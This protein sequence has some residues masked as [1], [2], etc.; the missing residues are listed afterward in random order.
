MPITP[1]LHDHTLIQAEYWQLLNG[2]CE[3]LGIH[4]NWLFD[5]RVVCPAELPEAYGACAWGYLPNNMFRIKLRCDLADEHQ[6]HWTIAHELL[7]ALLSPYGDLC[8]G[9]IGNVRGRAT[10]QVIQTR[11]E[12][13][14]D[15]FIEHM[16]SILIPE[17]R[18][19][20]IGDA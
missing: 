5:L 13:I 6:K 10:R 11:H 8:E 4:R 17:H 20:R 14:R 16:L 12:A 1:S 19:V 2:W 9:L 18:F 15:E 7:E 3:R